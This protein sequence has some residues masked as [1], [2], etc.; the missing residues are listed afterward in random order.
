MRHLQHVARRTAQH[1]GLKLLGDGLLLYKEAV[2]SLPIVLGQL[3]SEPTREFLQVAQQRA[4]GLRAHAALGQAA[5]GARRGQLREGR[6]LQEDVARHRSL[7]VE[8]GRATWRQTQ[9]RHAISRP[10]H[11]SPQLRAQSLQEQGLV[12]RRQLRVGDAGGGAAAGRLRDGL[13]VLQEGLQV[14]VL[15]E[16]AEHAVHV[17]L[18]QLHGGLEHVQRQLRQRRHHA[19]VAFQQVRE[20]NRGAAHHRTAVRVRQH[21]GADLLLRQRVVVVDPVLQ[22][23]MLVDLVARLHSAPQATRSFLQ[24][25]AVRVMQRLGLVV[26]ERVALS[27]ANPRLSARLLTRRGRARGRGA[28]APR[29]RDLQSVLADQAVVP[30]HG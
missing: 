23:C 1:E 7:H 14:A 10:K 30:R 19:E 18:N 27:S 6:D 28:V 2:H 12:P 16:Q 15:H 26:P 13:E 17:E 24:G 11:R 20:L 29:E 22:Q 3:V 4:H 5:E 8:H 9:G 25:N 21:R